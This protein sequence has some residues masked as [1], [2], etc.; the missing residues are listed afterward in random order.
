MASERQPHDPEL[1]EEAR[2]V[3][4]GRELGEE[5]F[6]GYPE[7]YVFAIFKDAD[8]AGEAMRRLG[9]L[10]LTGEQ[11]ATFTGTEGARSIDSDGSEHGLGAR[12]LRIV[13]QGAANIDHMSEYEDAAAAGDVVLGVHAPDDD[14]RDQVVSVLL[15]YDTRAVNYF[16]GLVVE[17]LRA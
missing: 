7:D 6:F 10:G 3:E 16:G 8:E 1:R 4:Q 17:T 11:V 9:E 12:L 2:A 13:Q 15:D 5:E 14:L